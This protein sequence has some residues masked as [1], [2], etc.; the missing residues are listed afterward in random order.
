[1]RTKLF[2]VAAVVAMAAVVLS[3]AAG[4]S[5]GGEADNYPNK[6]ITYLTVW[7]PGGQSDRTARMQQP[8]LEKALGQKIVMDYKVG[9]G[10]AVGWSEFVRSKA[11]GYS[12]VGTNL[13]TIVTQPMMEDVGYKTEQFLPLVDFQYSPLVF[14]VKNDSPYKDMKG[15]VDAAKANPGKLSIGG[16][17]LWSITHIMALEMQKQYGIQIQFVPHTGTAPL[18]TNWLGGHVDSAIIYT[19]DLLRQKDQG[20]ALMIVEDTKFP[21][22]EQYPVAKEVGFNFSFGVSRGIALQAGAPDYAAKKLEKAFLD[23][24][25]DPEIIAQM[26]KEGF[27]SR[28][29]GSTEF[30]KEIEAQTKMYADYLKDADIK[31]ADPT[32]K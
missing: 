30:K 22:L 15:F 4:C 26:T 10:G 6:P 18:I 19:D 12:M 24:A 13:P 29:M 7:D 1:M 28:A 2:V 21:G 9:G 27:L 17:A 11:D 23:I 20:R 16:V 32:K 31:K 3:A 25:K 5:R 8:L 14:A